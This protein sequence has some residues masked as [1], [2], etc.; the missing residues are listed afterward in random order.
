MQS[1]LCFACDAERWKL[2]KAEYIEMFK[3]KME[4]PVVRERFFPATCP[5]AL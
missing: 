2:K 3:V 5:M 1:K 4:I